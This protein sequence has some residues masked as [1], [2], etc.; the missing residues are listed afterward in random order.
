MVVSLRASPTIYNR[1][2]MCS[3]FVMN[4][5]GTIICVGKKIIIS[6]YLVS[7]LNFKLVFLGKTKSQAKI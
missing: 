6:K 1:I 5:R 2:F 3:F 4:K 7:L